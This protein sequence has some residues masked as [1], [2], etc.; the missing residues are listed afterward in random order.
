MGIDKYIKSEI[1]NK[2]GVIYIYNKKGNSLTK[3]MLRDLELEINTLSNNEKINSIILKSDYDGIFCSGA[4]F[5]ELLKIYDFIDAENY[6]FGFANILNAMRKSPKI[7][8]SQI[9]GKVVGGGV[10]IVCSSDYVV[11]SGRSSI[12]LSE[13]SIGIGPFVIQPAIEKKIGINYFTE[14]ALFPKEWKDSNW[15]LEKGVFNK[16]FE[17]SNELENEVSKITNDFSYYSSNAIREL[18]SSIWSS[19]DHWENLLYQKAEITAKLLL[20]K[21]TKN[22]LEKYKP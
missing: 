12:K 2:T 13:I 15:C 4:N 8:I 19:Y 14:L 11:A 7:I 22:I 6:F 9:N 5:D 16:V 3:K 20:S 21:D 10:G 1:S 17:T 18:K